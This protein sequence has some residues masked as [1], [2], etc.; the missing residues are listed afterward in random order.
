MS[1]N[2]SNVLTFE[3]VCAEGSSAPHFCVQLKSF[4]IDSGN[5]I[6]GSS[7]VSLLSCHQLTVTSFPTVIHMDSR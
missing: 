4:C 7:R 3:A 1:F 6:G 2:I 5:P